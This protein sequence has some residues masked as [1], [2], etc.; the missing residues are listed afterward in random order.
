VSITEREVQSVPEE[1]L[2]ERE[3]RARTLEAG[4]LELEVH[5]WAQSVPYVAVDG[6]RCLVGGINAARG[7]EANDVQGAYHVFFGGPFYERPMTQ[8]LAGWNDKPGRTAEEVIFV[9]RLR[10]SEIRDGR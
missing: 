3:Q 5:G 8:T 6:T 7:A 2:T 1:V 10:A 4:A 9:L